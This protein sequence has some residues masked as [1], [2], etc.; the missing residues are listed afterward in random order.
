MRAPH[1]PVM[2]AEVLAW[3]EIQPGG[4]YVDCTA[5]AGGHAAAVAERVGEGGRLIALDR[6][7]AAVALATERLK[8]FERA[9]VVHAAYGELNQVLDGMG[10]VSLDGALID[11]GCS[12]MQLDTPERGFSFQEDG[13]LDMRMDRHAGA[14]A[15]ELLAAWDETEIAKAL[16]EFGDV[17]YAGR[18]ARAIH[19]RAIGGRLDTTHDL[20]A[21][22]KEALPHVQGQPDEVRTVFQAV[23]IAVNGELAQLE[24]GAR[25]ALARLKPG[26]RLVVLTFHSG[27]DRVIKDLFREASRAR[28]ERWPD[29][30]TKSQT[31][32]VA[33]L[34]TPKPVLPGAVEMRTNPRSKSAKLRA[35]AR[36]D[37][38]E[39]LA[40]L[41]D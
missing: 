35:V 3:L 31:P 36:V 7:V 5:G 18:I 21:A 8:S 4:T 9:C 38:V 39:R 28:I 40:V 37:A 14:P 20:V 34:L 13:P 15:S 24:A 25:Q 23:R 19:A 11:A 29:G 33:R 1:V 10:V 22:V 27:E 12:S 32:P 17:P 41:E 26:G 16:V 2:L 6:D 30:R